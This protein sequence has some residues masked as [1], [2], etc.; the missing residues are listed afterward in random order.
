MGIVNEDLLKKPLENGLDT[1]NSSGNESDGTRVLRKM[2]LRVHS[3]SEDQD[4]TPLSPKRHCR[5]SENYIDGLVKVPSSANG[6]HPS[7]DNCV[8]L[9]QH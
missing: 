9:K 5:L 7:A 4:H 3:N 1:D 6:R 2:R 8:A